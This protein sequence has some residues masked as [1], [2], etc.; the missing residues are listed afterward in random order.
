MLESDE[1]SRLPRGLPSS[2]FAILA[3]A[4]GILT[5][6]GL[7]LGGS[8]QII[9]ILAIFAPTGIVAWYL[10]GSVTQT[11][12]LL[13][14]NEQLF[15]MG[16][17]WI[18]LGP[19]PGR[20]VLLGLLICTIP[21]TFKSSHA[22]KGLK[23]STHFWIVFYGILAPLLLLGWSLGQG[24]SIG[25]ALGDTLRFGAVLAV[26]PTLAFLTTRAR[27]FGAWLIGSSAAITALF[28]AMTIL[29]FDIRALFVDNWVY[30]GTGLATPVDYYRIT[31]EPLFYGY[32]GL[33][34]GLLTLLT[35]GRHRK[36]GTIL[37]VVSMLPAALNFLRGP[38][39]GVFIV[40]AALALVNSLSGRGA[41]RT[42]KLA[43]LVLGAL[44][45]SVYVVVQNPEAADRTLL[46]IERGGS[47]SLMGAARSA[48]VDITMTGWLNAPLLGHGVGARIVG[49]SAS[50]GASIEFQWGMILYRMGLFGLLLVIAPMLLIIKDLFLDRAYERSASNLYEFAS[51]GAGCTVLAIAIASFFNPYLAS[52][53]TV[54]LFVLYFSKHIGVKLGGV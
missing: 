43:P 10:T 31:F 11:I 45:L 44:L 24:N 8:S 53:M 17:I 32:I 51:D 54:T 50:P 16:G 27:L 35:N 33:F 49:Y 39:L 18:T 42:A 12:F 48:Q 52:S 41:L 5:A 23:P 21:Y 9:A 46:L 47:S 20:A 15:G 36:L 3:A 29:P 28:T 34:A 40:V 6:L 1:S 14:L 4:A 25:S 13:W 38:L 2:S 19:I 37:L 26:Y 30:A 22:V 7:T